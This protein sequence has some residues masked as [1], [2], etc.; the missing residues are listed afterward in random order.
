MTM[1]AIFRRHRRRGPQEFPALGG[2]NRRDQPK[3]SRTSQFDPDAEY[4]R[5][6]ETTEP[7]AWNLT[8]GLETG[9]SVGGGFGIASLPK[10]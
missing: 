3:S 1:Q 9:F 5:C 4:S 10:R 7:L 2:T 6:G 8:R